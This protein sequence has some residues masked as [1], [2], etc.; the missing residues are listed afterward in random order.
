MQT[1]GLSGETTS[2]WKHDSRH[3]DFALRIYLYIQSLAFL[4]FLFEVQAM[5][6]TQLVRLAARQA[7]KTCLYAS[8]EFS[9]TAS[10]SAEVELTIGEHNRLLSMIALIYFRWQEGLY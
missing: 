2:T 10:R 1:L 3:S 8:R 5:L 9:A 6:P 4:F 7:R